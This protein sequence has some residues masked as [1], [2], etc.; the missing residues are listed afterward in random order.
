VHPFVFDI[1]LAYQNDK[2]NGIH[3]HTHTH[4]HNT[5]INSVLN[6]I[7]F[8]STRTIESRKALSKR[9]L[10][11]QGMLD[12]QVVARKDAAQ[13]LSLLGPKWASKV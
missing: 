13:A 11:P 9:A 7:I 8:T 1:H 4:T 12:K 6:T 2:K 3:T 10:H 5:D